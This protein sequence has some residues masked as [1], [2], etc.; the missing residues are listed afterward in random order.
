MHPCQ[1]SLTLTCTLGQLAI[2]V[3]LG[4]LISTWSRM[5]ICVAFAPPAGTRHPL[6][7]GTASP[8]VAAGGDSTI[9]S[10]AFYG[11]SLADSVQAD[12]ERRG[13][14][15]DVVVPLPNRDER[16][17]YGTSMRHVARLHITQQLARRFANGR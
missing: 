4:A 12:A 17:K 8:T 7:G 14:S 9:S 3:V 15:G 13:S 10:G 11:G 5:S 1:H 2:G 16:K 6:P